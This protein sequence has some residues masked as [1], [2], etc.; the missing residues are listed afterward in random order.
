MSKARTPHYI[1]AYSRRYVLYFWGIKMIETKA[2]EKRNAKIREELE[3][4]TRELVQIDDKIAS[5]S[6]K[7]ERLP[8]SKLD[9]LRGLVDERDRLLFEKQSKENRRNHLINLI[10]TL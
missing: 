3:G 1:G 10:N 5:I 2:E 4:L 9:Q 7:I 8:D 6:R